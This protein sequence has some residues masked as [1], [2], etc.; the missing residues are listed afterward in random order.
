MS[1]SNKKFLWIC[2][3]SSCG[4]P[5]KGENVLSFM[6]PGEENRVKNQWAAEIISAREKAYDVKDAAV[7]LYLAIIGNIGVVR[8]EVGK[9]LRESLKN[10]FGVSRWWFHKISQ[11]YCE[12]DPSFDYIIQILLIDKLIDKFGYD[13]IKI[14]GSSNEV[15]KVLSSKYHVVDYKTK[16]AKTLLVSS[17]K[18][19]FRRVKLFFRNIHEVSFLKGKYVFK[20]SAKILLSNFWDW[21]VKYNGATGKFYDK[22]YKNLPHKLEEHK[23]SFC[24]LLWFDSRYQEG[25]KKRPLKEAYEPL[26]RSSNFILLQSFLGICDVLAC[27]LD[28]SVYFIFRK[29]NKRLA[30]RKVFNLNGFDFYAVFEILFVEGFLDGSIPNYELICLSHKRVAEKLKPNKVLSFLEFFPFSRAVNAGIKSG[31]KETVLY[32]MQHASYSREKVF[33]MCEANL[34]VR[35][36]EDGC[37]IPKPDYYFAMGELGKEIFI[38]NGYKEE[39]VLLTGSARYDDLACEQIEEIKP[40]SKIKNILIAASLH[41]EKEINMIEAVFEAF[42]DVPDINITV[43]PHPFADISKHEKFNSFKNKINV[44]KEISLEEDLELADVVIFS[45]S[46]VGEEAF[47][48]GKIVWHWVSYEYDASVFRDIGIVAKFHDINSLLNLYEKCVEYPK[49]NTPTVEDRK[50]V[51][52]KCFYSGDSLPSENIARILSSTN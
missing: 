46:T 4:D 2:Y 38:Q 7:G 31:N 21:S 35:N 25:L 22:Y 14:I 10:S 29:W 49:V 3:D 20:G 36:N 18:A 15:V 19:L 16:E 33:G 24:W 26:K 11:K 6:S 9:T 39:A 44:S 28:F 30:F 17:I 42:K 37:A 5:G 47:V 34:E 23:A 40:I 1:D 43:R 27:F 13:H 50:F 51:N 52:R 45:Y 32:D 48:R 41:I 8:S 12:G